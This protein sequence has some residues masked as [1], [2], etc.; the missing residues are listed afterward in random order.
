M[1]EDWLS[2]FYIKKNNPWTPQNSTKLLFRNSWGISGRL[3]WLVWTWWRVPLD[4]TGSGSLL[5]G[6]VFALW[7]RSDLAFWRLRTAFLLM[8][9]GLSVKTWPVNTPF[10]VPAEKNGLVPLRS[11]YIS[12]PLGGPAAEPGLCWSRKQAWSLPAWEGPQ[13]EVFTSP[14]GVSVGIKR[15]RWWR[16]LRQ[17]P[18]FL[19]TVFLHS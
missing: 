1:K 11:P 6:V 18:V 14:R 5:K 9:F 17:C 16:V 3:V 2:A 10:I 19:R 15:C 4:F 8:W 13:D 7:G 12:I